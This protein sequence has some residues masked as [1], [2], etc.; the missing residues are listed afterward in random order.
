VQGWYAFIPKN[1]IL[2]YFGEGL[3]ME[4]FGTIFYGHLVFLRSFGVFNV[5]LVYFVVSLVYFEVS[6]AYFKVS[7]AY[8]VD[9]LE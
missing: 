1:P 8:F 6:L 3:G 4:D 2:V 9:R 7:L 5:I